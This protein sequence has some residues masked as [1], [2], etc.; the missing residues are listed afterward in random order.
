M[1][2]EQKKG[3]RKR[4]ADRVDD[5]PIQERDWATRPRDDNVPDPNDRGGGRSKN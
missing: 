5:G 2:R 4:E 1:N 3:V